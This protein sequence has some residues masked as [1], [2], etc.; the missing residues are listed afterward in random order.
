MELDELRFS[1]EHVWVYLVDGHEALIG[2]S[3]KVLEEND[4]VTKI[5]LVG[6]GEEIIKDEPFGRLT[7]AMFESVVA[8]IV[9]RTR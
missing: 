2:L 1:P 5:R 3:E 8:E 6:E 4:E 7:T 9:G